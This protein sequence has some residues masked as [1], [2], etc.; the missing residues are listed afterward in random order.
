MR[1]RAARSVGARGYL[2]LDQLV[3]ALVGVGASGAGLSGRRR[4]RGRPSAALVVGVSA[5]PLRYESVVRARLIRETARANL[6]SS[7]VALLERR[8]PG[9][10]QPI[11]S[12]LQTTPSIRTNLPEGVVCMRLIHGA[13]LLP[14]GRCRV[15]LDDGR[16]EIAFARREVPCPQRSAG[17]PSVLPPARL[18]RGTSSLDMG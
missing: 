1:S 7:R 9:P 5:S 10:V 4:V 6:S 18:H 12:L 17:E 15:F 3:L 8:R 16:T 13:L 11:G 2:R 14:S